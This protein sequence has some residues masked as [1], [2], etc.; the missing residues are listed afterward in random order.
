MCHAT[1]KQLDHFIQLNE[2]A[3]SDIEWWH[4]SAESW[5]GVSMLS[6][7]NCQHPA[8]VITSD[9]SIPIPVSVLF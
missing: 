8:A 2:E 4:R 1:A 7:L 6:L 5:N 9:A 3:R